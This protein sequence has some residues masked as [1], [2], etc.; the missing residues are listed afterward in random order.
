MCFQI[1]VAQIFQR[2]RCFQNIMYMKTMA[3]PTFFPLKIHCESKWLGCELRCSLL[4]VAMLS[5]CLDSFVA[6][7]AYVWTGVFLM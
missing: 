2:Y 4:Q 3:R 7:L 1:S 6:G 5:F